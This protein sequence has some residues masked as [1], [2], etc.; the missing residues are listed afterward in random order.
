[1]SRPHVDAVQPEPRVDRAGEG[2]AGGTG[3]V[4]GRHEL[5]ALGGIVPGDGRRI[6]AGGDIEV[7]G[8]VL[9]IRHAQVHRI[10]E[11]LTPGRH[12]DLAPTAE[13]DPAAAAGDQLGRPGRDGPGH[14]DGA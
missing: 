9:A 4:A 13:G 14:V 7:Y 1:V 10:T 12:S 3:V 11:N 8:E 6:A 2:C 5:S